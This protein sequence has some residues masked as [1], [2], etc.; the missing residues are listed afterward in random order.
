MTGVIGAT[1]VVNITSDT[2]DWNVITDVFGGVAPTLAVKLLI[3]NSAIMRSSSTSIPAMDLRGLPAGS[4]VK[5]VNTGHIVGRG[6]AG[7]KGG[8]AWAFYDGGL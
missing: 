8:S 2:L 4:T 7:G 3:I 1:Q 5:L 6:G